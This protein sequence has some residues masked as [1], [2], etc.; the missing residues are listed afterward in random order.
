MEKDKLQISFDILRE[1]LFLY[2]DAVR[3]AKTKYLSD[4]ISNH[5]NR[6]R[7]LFNTINSVI[8]PPPT[9]HLQGSSATCENF[10]SFFVD[11]V[12]TIRSQISPPAYD[13]SVPPYSSFVLNH[14]EPVSPSTLAEVVSHLKPSMCHLDIIIF[15]RSL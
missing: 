10:L 2:Q 14:L 3:I 9:T 4:I 5:S 8:N 13:P 7:V 1:A 11:K 15:Q 6:S 12:A